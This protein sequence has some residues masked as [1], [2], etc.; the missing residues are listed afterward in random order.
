MT[1]EPMT[2]CAVLY[3]PDSSV[4][5]PE[6][7]RAARG[8][9]DLVLVTSDIPPGSPL[10][11]VLGAVGSHLDLPQ[12]Q[13][14]AAL[15][16][17]GVGGVVTFADRLVDSADDLAGAL[18]ARRG[19]VDGAWDKLTQ[20]RLL[21]AVGASALG[22]RGVASEA[23]LTAARHQ[24]GAEGMVKP[25]RSSTGRGI[26]AV[27]AADRSAD[28]WARVCDSSR[29][30][31]ADGPGFMYEPM[32]PWR[33]DSRAEA[34]FVSVETVS[35]GEE[36]HHVA[37]F[38]KLPL[39]FGF[40]ETGDIG[41]TRR[42]RDEVVEIVATVDAALSA[43]EV[44]DRVT[45][46]EVA[47]TTSGPQ[48][49]EVNGRLGGYVQ[50]MC[51][52]LEPGLD[53]AALALDVAMGHRA[54]ATPLAS[55]TVACSVQVPLGTDSED[56]VRRALAVLRTQPGVRSVGMPTPVH[57]RLR[58]V[59]GWLSGPSR[60]EVRAQL[61]DAVRALAADPVVAA[62]LDEPSGRGRHRGGLTTLR[63]PPRSPRPGRRGCPR[64][65]SAPAGPRVPARHR[66]RQRARPPQGSP[67]PR[68]RSWS[69]R[70]PVP[71]CRARRSSVVP[72]P[73][74]CRG[75]S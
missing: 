29:A 47:V 49:I 67:R 62:A 74:G 27:Q 39:A 23:D 53:M 72:R 35:T 36:R 71:R 50:G 73:R 5:L 59:G 65:R 31:L 33:R 54:P 9:C 24:L 6:L 32:L 70:Q 68:R 38:D 46:T 56:I 69:R 21:D 13:W 48:V 64:R 19:S 41:L 37:V 34:P 61:S 26:V 18:R 10:A 16:E 3:D 51:Q 25:R 44:R 43:L 28:V 58:Y 2:R 7:A 12:G 60:R 1:P 30:L 45:H 22:C 42:S 66:S 15:R 63:W 17:A 4:T 75:R 40:A 20:R 11:R 57:A 14:E 55:Q 52:V 8:R